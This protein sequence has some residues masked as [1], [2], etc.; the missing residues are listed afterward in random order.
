[1]SHPDR[2]TWMDYVYGE[3]DH[4]ESRRLEEHLAS[5]AQCAEQVAAWRRTMGLLDECAEPTP[6]ETRRPIRLGRVARWAMAAA[7]LLLAGYTAG[8]V[9][10]P[11]RAGLA[12]VR[13]DLAAARREVRDD[14]LAQA[15]REMDDKALATLAACRSMTDERLAELVASFDATHRSDMVAL[16]TVTEREL[17]RT[18]RQIAALAYEQ[19]AR[20]GEGGSQESG[21]P[22]EGG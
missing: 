13:A 6:A 9:S 18:Q 21:T 16:A 7:V 10:A 8:R 4:P 3:A 2:E 15:R 5:C 14:V 1:M 12:A 22:T 17:L 11:G 19:T 20:A